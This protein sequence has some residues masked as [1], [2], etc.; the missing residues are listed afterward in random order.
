[1]S[2]DLRLLESFIAVAET[3]SFSI[4][5]K[6]TNTVQSAISTHIKQLEQTTGQSLVQRGRGKPVSL[7]HEGAAFL[8]QARRLL[9]LADQ[10]L[11]GSRTSPDATPLLLGTTITFALSIVP[12]ALRLFAADP[13]APQVAVKTAR[14]HELMALL[15]TGQIDLALVFDQGAHPMR[16]RTVETSL[17]WVARKTFTCPEGMPLPLAFLEDARDLRR[18]AFSAVDATP[19]VQASLTTCPDPIGLRSLLLAGLA[20]SI[21]PDAAII[22]PL[23]N[24]GKRLALPSLDTMQVCVYS[25]SEGNTAD[26]NSL[27]ENLVSEI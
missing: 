11:H 25:R 24:V 27:I 7:T 15:E 16:K 12:K 6:R 26:T 9:L 5:A 22:P 13:Q 18:H 2:F 3:R 10:I 23:R 4:A 14:S 20:V 17:A 19:S 1:M 8:V 21:L